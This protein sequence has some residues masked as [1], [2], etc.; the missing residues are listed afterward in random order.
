MS[1][2]TDLFINVRLNLDT[3][4]KILN[5]LSANNDRDYINSEKYISLVPKIISETA[6][7][8]NVLNRDYADFKYE[9][10]E[11]DGYYRLCLRTRHKNKDEDFE[12]LINY[13]IPYINKNESIG[14]IYSD[15]S[16]ILHKILFEPSDSPDI[17]VTDIVN[18]V[19]DV[20]INLLD[21]SVH[22]IKMLSKDNNIT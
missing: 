12:R 7:R 22:E 18:N 10:S 5:W 17:L 3:D 15:C 1:C 19:N 11:S 14:Y 21:M 8:C 6:S 2:C 16:R 13:L 20:D 4:I 9:F